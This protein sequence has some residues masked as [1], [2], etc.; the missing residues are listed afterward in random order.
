M[1]TFGTVVFLLAQTAIIL[2]ICTSIVTA[3]RSGDKEEIE[4]KAQKRYEELLRTAE[5]R[6][7]Q[8]LVI[9]DEMKK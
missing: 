6:V 1:W 9:H 5:I 7:T 2:M 4:E 8:R 3:I